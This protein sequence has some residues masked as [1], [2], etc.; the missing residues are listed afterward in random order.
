MKRFLN[1]RWYRQVGGVDVTPSRSVFP[2][3]TRSGPGI[4][5]ILDW[6]LL[7]LRRGSYWRGL[8]RRGALLFRP[9][10]FDRD[11]IGFGCIP[12]SPRKAV[13][14]IRRGAFGDTSLPVVE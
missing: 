11:A 8:L 9:S 14:L 4:R 7:M 6:A 12:Y 5:V 3:L 10:V 13:A 2:T 1:H